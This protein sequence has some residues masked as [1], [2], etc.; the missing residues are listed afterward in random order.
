VT[1][2]KLLALVVFWASP[3]L[4]GL[5]TETVVS[6]SAVHHMPFDVAA[7]HLPV[8]AEGVVTNVGGW[9]Y[10]LTV[11][12]GADGVYVGLLAGAPRVSVGQRV[13]IRGTTDP[14]RFAPMIQ[15]AKIE[16]KKV[17]I[18]TTGS[19]PRPYPAKARELA[20]GEL[21][22]R[23][24]EVHGVVRAT[25]RGALGD[26]FG[27]YMIV[28]TNPG[29]VHVALARGINLDPAQ[30]VDATIRAAGVVSVE[31]NNRRQALGASVVVN[32]REDLS[33]LRISRGSA[34]DGAV[35]PI[36]DIFRW[37]AH[38][39]WSHRIRVKG[40]LTLQRPGE[41]L[42]LQDRDQ[43]IRVES[44]GTESLPLGRRYEAAGFAVPAD[45]GP[46]LSNSVVGNEGET[47]ALT[48]LFRKASEVTPGADSWLLMRLQARLVEIHEA[49]TGVMLSL[50][51][52]GTRFAALA[53]GSAARELERIPLG[54][55]LDVTGINEVLVN[56]L[57]EPQGFRLLIRSPK[58]IFL[59][60]AGPWLNAANIL[61]TVL[62]LGTFALL[63]AVWALTLRYRVR[64][65]TAWIEERL[66]RE[67]AS[68]WLQSERSRILELISRNASAQEVCRA[69]IEIVTCGSPGAAISI[70][71]CS[72][73]NWESF[74]S[75]SEADTESSHGALEL[76][77]I[78]I[79]SG[80][81]ALS[82]RL[83][84][85]GDGGDADRELLEIC[86]ETLSIALE[87]QDLHLQLVRQS[88]CDPLT[89]LPNRRSFDNHLEH[90][91]GNAIR[92][93]RQCAVA[94]LDMDNFKAIN[95][96]LGHAAGDLVLQTMA[97]RFSSVL[98]KGDMVARVGGDEFT[99][100]LD[101][102]NGR[103]EAEE[104]ACRLSR[105]AARPIDVAGFEVRPAVSVGVAVYPL[106]G[107]TANT[108]KHCA[109]IRMY[110]AKMKGERDAMPTDIEAICET[111]VH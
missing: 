20:S 62:L 88:Q 104:L 66:C 24:V 73:G 2:W 89:Q 15:A 109:D 86:R 82:A 103:E 27:T 100:V 51:D 102:P 85:R 87:H 18:Q 76:G 25:A 1:A 80:S 106:D 111:L 56:T 60:R 44:I 16:M 40:V 28:D 29:S 7:R 48:P 96:T 43:A 61:W 35:T 10:G 6:I 92:T 65:Q 94:V 98:R 67:R 49:G 32:R 97:R 52:H 69:L 11:Q 79:S 107:E 37:G 71:I 45:F 14:G 93:H 34:L 23:F 31:F 78:E 53:P 57:R 54:S 50:D 59:R 105:E 19:L 81:G 8:V 17:E 108:L 33:V 41:F 68:S 95:D 99:C 90:V 83:E 47:E 70:G 21:D 64:R 36:S 84:L 9:P 55:E 74:G 4:A 3:S 101:D 110:R 46:T 77:A 22:N 42:I 5:V 39:D 26:G 38:Q 91:L 13:I 58:D 72:E 12:D 30:F 75:A 63:F